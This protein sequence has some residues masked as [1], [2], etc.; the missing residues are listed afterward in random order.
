MRQQQRRRA[1][2]IAAT[3]LHIQ[4]CWVL[5]PGERATTRTRLSDKEDPCKQRVSFLPFNF[6]N[7]NYFVEKKGK[8][9]YG[10]NNMRQVSRG[11]SSPAFQPVTCGSAEEEKKKFHV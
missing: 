8:Q 10:F 2:K 6:L 3:A 4:P 1:P 9:F 7:Y 11:T 5:N